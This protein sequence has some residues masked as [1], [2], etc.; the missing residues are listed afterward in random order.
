MQRIAKHLV[1]LTILL[2]FLTALTACGEDAP[3]NAESNPPK[4]EEDLPAGSDLISQ[5]DAT[6]DSITGVS[7]SADFQ[8]ATAEG[9]V[10]GSFTYLGDR[11]DK[12]R[13]EITSDDASLNGMVL[14]TDGEKG[15]AYSPSENLVLVSNKSQFKAQLNEQPELRELLNFSEKVQDNGVDQVQEAQTEGIETVNG[16]ET[17]KVK[18]TYGG[19]ELEGITVTYYIDKESSLPQRIEINIKRDGLEASGFILAKGE[20]DTSSNFDAAQFIFTPPDG[21][22]VFDLESL[23]PLPGFDSS[24]LLGD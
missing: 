4:T 7:F 9:P 21:A 14:V 24:G 15:W 1:S 11:P 2:L 3:P 6:I 5:M 23:P 20:I 22:T 13:T 17:Y 12:S 16:R 8:F 19:E 10:K 18:A